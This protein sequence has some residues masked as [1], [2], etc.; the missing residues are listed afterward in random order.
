MSYFCFLGE[1]V[2]KKSY[3]EYIELIDKMFSE[4]NYTKVLK[5]FTT[6]YKEYDIT[7][8]EVLWVRIWALSGLNRVEE[9]IEKLHDLIVEKRYWVL[10]MITEEIEIDAIKRD[11]RYQKLMEISEQNAKNFSYKKEGKYEIFTPKNTDENTKLLVFLHG[12]Y[13]ATEEFSQIQKDTVNSIGSR[14]KGEFIVTIPYSSRIAPSG[15][16]LWY[17]Y[18]ESSKEIEKHLRI[19]QDEY[20]IMPSNIIITGGSAGAGVATEVALNNN[21]EVNKFALL[22]PH[23]PKLKNN[24][25]RISN[26]RKSEFFIYSSTNDFCMKYANKFSEILTQNNFKHVFH[27]PDGYGHF[28]PPEE[29]L[30]DR[31]IKYFK[32]SV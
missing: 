2:M 23:I 12:N 8:F 22:I 1:K 32:F 5:F 6:D 4:K 27:C 7:E 25:E 3:M 30:L 14:L 28:I 17:D 11:D 20:K 19:I 13:L 18:G 10:E 31:T 24:D 26:L 21:I 15:Q 16:S 29:N 9:A